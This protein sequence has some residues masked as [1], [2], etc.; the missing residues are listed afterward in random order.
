MLIA[1]TILSI[2]AI[3]Y[4]NSRSSV[5]ALAS[6][7]PLALAG[8]VEI[9]YMP[10][11]GVGYII[12]IGIIIGELLMLADSGFKFSSDRKASDK[13]HV[14]AKRWIWRIVIAITVLELYGPAV[15]LGSA[16][17]SQNC[18]ALASQGNSLGWNMY[19]NVVP[20]YWLDASAWMKTNIGPYGPRVLSWWDYGDWINWYG[21]SN[22]VLRGDNAVATSD[23]ATAEQYVFEQAEG[24][25][26]STMASFMD[27]IQAQY[28]V[29]DDQLIPKWS[30]LNF[31]AC[32]S[33]N[34][35]SMSFA[36][37][38]G[39]ARGAPYITGTSQCELDHS[40]AYLLIPAN[41]SDVSAFCQAG[42]TSESEVKAY[43]VAGQQFMNSTYCVP[44]SVYNFVGKAIPVYDSNGNATNAIVV[45][46]SLF[47]LGVVSVSGQQ[48]A[49]FMVLYKPNAPN[50]TVAD[51]PT[52]FYNSNFYRAFFFGQLPG[53]SLVYPQNF[54]GMNYVNN[55]SAIMILKLNNFSNNLPEIATKPA[56]VHNN[57]SVPG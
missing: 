17:M 28:I 16:A 5:L 46:R 35:T 54:T 3:Y 37:Q 10:H 38:Q 30:A 31:L 41:P 24:V 20:T 49:D 57:Y 25:N 48:F 19:C 13:T 26:A 9:K 14:G 29:F 22:A 39:S 11:F 7:W 34:Q 40:P 47:Y 1:F 55:T 27:S 32:I 42:N 2:L 52:K 33:A 45:P 53:F 6:I 44:T 4:R 8:M 51:A 50:Y 15:S 21:N 36:E 18:T 43:M 56:W 23:Y 12:A